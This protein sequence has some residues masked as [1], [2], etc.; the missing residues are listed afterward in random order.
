MIKRVCILIFSLAFHL[1]GFAQNEN[2]LFR[3]SKNY[4]NGSARYEGMAGS[5][6]ALGADVSAYQNNPAGY[7]RFSHS[8][9]GF[10]INGGS[11][12]TQ[13]SFNNQRESASKGQI[14]P[15]TIGL[16]FCKDVSRKGNG[17]LL[18]D[19]HFLVCVYY[20]LLIR[21]PES[22]IAH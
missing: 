17:F 19:S 12:I 1:I 20:L 3:Y 21:S 7:G 14:A 11:Q 16:L 13:S 6:G 8:T 22:Q 5:F 9:F 2:D 15:G 4:L 10:G 18:R